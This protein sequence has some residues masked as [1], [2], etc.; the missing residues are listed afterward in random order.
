MISLPGLGSWGPAKDT[1]SYANCLA[2]LSGMDN[3]VGYPGDRVLG[4]QQATSDVNTALHGAFAVQAA[5][6]HRN[7]T[8]EGQYIEVAQLETMVGCLGEGIMEYVMNGRSLG[9]QGNR[10]PSMAPHNNYRCQGE[11]KWI[12]IAVKTDEEWHSLCRAMGKPALAGDERFADMSSRLRNCEELDIIIT[13]WTLNHDAYEVMEIL[14]AA[15]VAAMPCLD[16]GDRYTDPQYQHRGT[17]IFF[18]HPVAGDMLLSTSP[19]RMSDAD[20]DIYRAAPL[21][22]EHNQ[23]VLGDLLG[24]TSEEIASLEEKQVLY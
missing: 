20:S 11:D 9:L 7:R 17:F 19:W 2:A 4:M 13:E 10:H 5:L 8:G 16:V 15:G 21:L 23:Y 12:S 18:P 24:M 6:L 3:M 14:Q 22:G 1:P